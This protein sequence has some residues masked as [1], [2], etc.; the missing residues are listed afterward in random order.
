MRIVDKYDKE[1][2]FVIPSG[3]IDILADDGRQLF[4]INELQGGSLEINTS[5]V[6]KHKDKLLDTRITIEPK[7]TNCLILSRKEYK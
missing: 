4:S 6:C 5:M 3:S 2:G 1:V 7:A